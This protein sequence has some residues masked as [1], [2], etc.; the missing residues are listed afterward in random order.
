MKKFTIILFGLFLLFALVGCGKKT[1]DINQL[2]EDK[3]YHYSNKDL[4]FGIALPSEFE[5]YQV[6]RKNSAD[7]IDIEF[8]IPTND[9]IYAQEVPGYAK[10][11]I[12]RIYKLDYWRNKADESAEKSG[13]EKIGENKASVYAVKFWSDLPA[14]W[15]NKWNEDIKIGIIK[16]LKID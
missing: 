12:I 5:Y 14:D 10:P 4:G 13:F 16:S 1:P 7:Y 8:F 9:R 2:S 3:G 11:V 15:Q 6:Q